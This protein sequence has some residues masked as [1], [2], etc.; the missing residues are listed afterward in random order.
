MFALANETDGRRMKRP[1]LW[2]R[3]LGS[4]VS[5]LI[6]SACTYNPY[7]NRLRNMDEEMAVVLDIYQDEEQIL[8]F[9]KAE[10]RLEYRRLDRTVVPCLGLRSSLRLALLL[11]GLELDLTDYERA[12]DILKTCIHWTGGPLLPAYI[13]SR[14]AQVEKNQQHR[15][16]IRRVYRQLHVSRGM[17]KRL[18]SKVVNLEQNNVTLKEKSQI[19]EEKSQALEQQ[20]EAVADIEH[21]IQDRGQQ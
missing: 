6:L 11:G 9:S 8:D 7:A 18:R 2:G 21:E 15:A 12:Q 19:L 16:Q 20:I 10:R 1:W 4:L 17:T 3:W 5:I 13:R 14:L